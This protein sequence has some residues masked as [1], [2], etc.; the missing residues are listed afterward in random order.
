MLAYATET[1]S[2]NE[3]AKGDISAR[4]RNLVRGDGGVDDADI[5][6]LEAWDITTGSRDVVIAVI[7]TGVDYTHRDLAANAWQNPGEIPGNGVD[8][9]GN[10][11]GH[12]GGGTFVCRSHLCR[13]ASTTAHRLDGRGRVPARQE[14]ATVNAGE[15]MHRLAGEKIHQ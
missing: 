1:F 8:D 10:G 2:N 5:D 13:P 9:D 3:K 4:P 7:D 14:Q 11:F 15:I 6:A 12:C